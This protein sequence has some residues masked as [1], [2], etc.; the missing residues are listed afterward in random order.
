ERFRRHPRRAGALTAAPQ[1]A[2]MAESPDRDDRTIDVPPADSPSTVSFECHA[3]EDTAALSS[4]TVDFTP[5]GKSVG[6]PQGPPPDSDGS[7][8]SDHTVDL[9]GGLPDD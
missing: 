2:P 3:A 8:V 9:A 1:E 6:L 4:P 5:A 7:P